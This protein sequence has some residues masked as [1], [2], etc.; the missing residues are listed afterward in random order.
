MNFNNMDKRLVFDRGLL[1]PVLVGVL[2]I[3]GIC[4]VLAALRFNPG[5]PAI[6]V[7]QTSTPFQYLFIGT[8]PVLS[9]GTTEGTTDGEE[10]PTSTP[11][12]FLPPTR[13][14]PLASPGSLITLPAATNTRTPTSSPTSASTAPLSAGTYDDTHNRLIYSGDWEVQN[15]VAGANLS[16][17]HVSS[18]L[19]TPRNS[20]AFQF[21]GQEIHI[22]YQAGPSL[23]TMSLNIDNKVYEISENSTSTDIL[24]WIIPPVTVGTH[25]VT[26][27]HLSGGS[28]NIDKIIVAEIP[29]T[30][31][32]TPTFTVTP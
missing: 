10:V 6:P 17:L 5:R 13:T 15:N 30:P 23:G 19:N 3:C 2:S 12:F 27:T 25:T 20:V 4:G 28:V 26:I 31:V 22:F 24:E 8:E 18:V 11:D 9:T 21:I 7:E 32:N 16:T 1:V 14:T 29:S